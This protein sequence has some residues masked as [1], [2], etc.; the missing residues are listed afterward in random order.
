MNTNSKTPLL[1]LNP[2]GERVY[3]RDYYCSKVS[4]ADYLNHPIDLLYLSGLLQSHYGLHLIDAIVDKL[5]AQKTLQMIEAL[6]PEVIIGLIGSVSYEEDVDFY[7]R[8]AAENHVPLVLSGD[9]LI[10]NRAERLQEMDFASALLHDFSDAV[11]CDYLQGR[12][13][14]LRNLTYRDGDEIVVTPIERA[15]CEAFALPVP[16]HHLFIDRNY[17][18]PFVRR[19]RFATVMTEFGCPYHCTFCIMSTLGWKIRPVPNVLEELDYVHKLGVRELFFLDQTF[20][21]QKPRALHLLD[22]M[23]R[24]EYGFGWVC[25]SRPDILDDE[26]LHAMKNAGC[27][28]LIL[29][30]ESGDD[31]VLAAA[32]K[33]YTRAQVLAGFERCQAHGLRTVAT[34][35]I[36]L[37]EETEESFQRTMEFLKIVPVDFVSF[38]VA[39]P[40]MGTPLRQ[41]AV[42]NNLISS[43][44]QIM[45]QSGREVAM[46]GFTLSR[47]QIAAMRQRA[48]REFYMNANYLKR[49]LMG[50]RSLDDARIQ[51]RQGVGLLRNYLRAW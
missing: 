30:L 13:D 41:K 25:F 2:P 37:P 50:L 8:L 19:R 1:L 11:V 43:D 35:I 23:Q 17:R 45:D 15:R 40:R 18:Y 49:R 39:V 7:R 6:Q 33:D 10:E 28:T 26:I 48:V 47:E 27:H 22:E 9:V 5:P 46:P 34:V 31:A 44:F 38:N 16:A 4:Q 12:R 42:K 14:D 20:A 24:H 36:G 32:K 21:L 51:L 29:G 3:L